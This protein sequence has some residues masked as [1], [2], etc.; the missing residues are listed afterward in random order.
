MQ[1]QKSASC[2]V[3]GMEQV[4][5]SDLYLKDFSDMFTGLA[6]KGI[7]N[8]YVGCTQGLELCL[9][10]YLISMKKK[11]NVT[12]TA[13]ITGTLE[14]DTKYWSSSTRERL[15]EALNMADTVLELKSAGI[16]ERDYKIS[17]L[18]EYIIVPEFKQVLC[19]K[20]QKQN[21]GK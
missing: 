1:N 18:C 20:S 7:T 2:Y 15:N 4:Q 12:V 17:A 5:N 9:L 11:R 6:A 3:F 14:D 16:R 19:L 21:K 13:A 8:F 10:E